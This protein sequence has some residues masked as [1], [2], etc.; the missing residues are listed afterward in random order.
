CHHDCPDTCVWDITVEGGR[1]VR[2]RGNADHPTTRGQLCP[3]VNRLLERVYHPDRVLR[4]LR[5][6]GSKGSGTFEE[7]SWQ[8]AL[9]TIADRFG[10]LIQQSGGESILQFSFD[11]TQGVIQK[12]VLADRFFDAI[13]ASDIRRHLCGVT[14]WLGASDVTG[15]PFGIDPEDLRHARTILLWGTNTLLTNRHLWPF[16]EEAREA[17]ATVVTIDPVRTV[18][19]RRSDDHIQLRP[20]SDIALVLGMVHVMETEGLLDH[21]WISESTT[22]WDDLWSSAVSMTPE[23]TALMTGVDS[24]RIVWLARTYATLRP[25]AIRTLVGPEHRRNGRETMRAISM[26]ASLTGAWRDVGGGLARSTQIYFE[27][28]LNYPSGRPERRAFN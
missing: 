15:R 6:R 19:A 16:I 12:G 2:I 14:A 13:G 5:R 3:K 24:V 23:R 25:A 22:G 9:D 4:P 11:G 10:E 20:G 18:T 17:G 26:L 21:D 8:E 27:T 28:A 1:A 7:I